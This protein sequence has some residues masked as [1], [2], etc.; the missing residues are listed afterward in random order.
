MYIKF[1]RNNDAYCLMSDVVN[2][3]YKVDIEEMT[4]HMHKINVSDEVQRSLA[5]QQIILPITPVI[6]KEFNVTHGGKMFIENALH[7]GQ[8]PTRIVFGFVANNAHVGS[9]KHNPFNWTHANVRKVALL[10]D[11]QVINGRPLTTNFADGDIMDGFWSL[12]RATNTRYANAG[13]LVELDDYKKGGYTLW[14]YD[15]SPSQCDDQFND[16]KQR[17]GLSL[18]I[19]FAKNLTT[20]LVLCVYLQFDS[21]I[22]INATGA[23]ITMYD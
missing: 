23:V 11:G 8:L 22:I 18:E 21:E 19:E 12:S 17:G 3:A 20:P 14:A 10:R 2:A 13:T 5:G 6:Q 9:Y 16:P 4:L 1:T 7:S 15:L